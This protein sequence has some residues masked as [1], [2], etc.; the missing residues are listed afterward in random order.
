MPE[1]IVLVGMM[2]SG[3]TTVGRLVARRLGRPFVDVDDAVVRRAGL[4]VSELFAG[5]G[6]AA[7]R[8]LE[9]QCLGDALGD[10]AGSGVADEA[11]GT[12]V[13]VGGGAVLDAANRA[14][15]ARSGP[16]VWLRAR[17]ET[18]AERLGG[19]EGRPLLAESTRDAVSTL[20]ALAADRAPLYEQV[21]S[22]VID[23]DGLSAEEVADRLCALAVVTP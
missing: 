23:V 15:M 1:H 22:V 2:G 5:Q 11:G 18:L 19:G 21:A 16:V 10:P 8:S 20:A 9:S 3:K 14:R 17:P 12:V 7:F 6:E 13:A 4:S